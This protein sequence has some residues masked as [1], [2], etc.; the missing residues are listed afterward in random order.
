MDEAVNEYGQNLPYSLE[1]EQSVLGSI[2]IDPEKLS[3][4]MNIIKSPSVFYTKAHQELYALMLKMF[5]ESRPIDFV[6]LLEEAGKAGEQPEGEI[7]TAEP[8][9]KPAVSDDD[10][11]ILERIFSKKR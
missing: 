8:E 5:G 10:W 2:L 4:V 11:D 9:A 3:D 7:P 6:T 1:A